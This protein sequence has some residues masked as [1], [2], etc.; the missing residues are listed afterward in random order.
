MMP[1]NPGVMVSNLRIE[2]ILTAC[3]FAEGYLF[4]SR[5]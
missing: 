4:L 5:F 2:M 1:V 3:V